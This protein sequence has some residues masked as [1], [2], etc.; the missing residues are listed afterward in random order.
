MNERLFNTLEI[1][2]IGSGVTFGLSNIH[3][4]LGIAI[5]I[6]EVF[7]IGFKIYQ[8]VKASIDSKNEKPLEEAI[9][10]AKE[11]LEQLQHQLEQRDGT[12]SSSET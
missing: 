5:L 12:N 11:H 10:E 8:S 9:E 3:N 2:A 6:L 7:L 1:G 4:I